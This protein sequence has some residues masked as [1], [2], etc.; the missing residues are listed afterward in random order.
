LNVATLLAQAAQARKHRPALRYGERKLTYA[1]LDR[2]V[3]AF[4]SAL[5]ARGLRPGD[6]VALFMRNCPEYVLSMFGA[7]SAGLVAVPVNARLV[8]RELEVILSDCGARALVFGD[9][10]GSIVSG[11]S[12]TE[13]EVLLQVGGA[14]DSFASFLAGGDPTAPTA[15][16]GPEAAAWLFYTSGTTGRPKGAELS[17][18]SLLAMT[19]ALLANV[20][21]F[22]PDDRVLHVAPLSHG[23]GLY[24][25]GSLARGAENVIFDGA[26]YDPAAVLELVERERVSV[27]CFMA[28]TMIAMLLDARP[29]TDTSSLRRVI[30][31]GG[32]IHLEHA[33]RMLQRFGPV[34]VQIYGQG[35]APMT[36]TSLAADAHDPLDP[37]ALG[38]AGLP[39]VGVEVAVVDVNGR[40]L[41]P[42]SQGEVCVRGDVVMNGYWR[43][44]EATAEALRGGWL[45]TG[46]LGR[47]DEQGRLFLLDRIHDTIISGGANIYP[48]EVEEVLLRHPGVK[49]VAVFGLPDELWGESVAAAIVLEPG[50]LPAEQELIEHCRR[51]AAGFKRPKHLFVVDELPRNAYGKVLRR[52]LRD[53]FRSPVRSPGAGQSAA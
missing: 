41:P 22:R 4:G 34:F 32:P 7:F 46:D 50:A 5:L 51:E 14:Q 6:R 17:H 9:D 45:H 35:E 2:R 10:E 26:G 20:C 33:R 39:Q 44:P 36:I 24:L 49:D 12:T 3:R 28:P 53:R 19:L 48:R 23:S 1:E 43:N 42:G 21:D 47:F 30:Y 40:P 15:E 52:E 38:S 18:R 16:V 31:G 25:I 11:L 29:A 37:D 8:A 13:P 27:I